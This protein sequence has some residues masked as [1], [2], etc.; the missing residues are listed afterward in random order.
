[1]RNY[2]LGI[3]IGTSAC[4][5]ALF[6]VE[7]TL[8]LSNSEKYPT[9]YPEAGWAEQ[10]PLDWWNAVKKTVQLTIEQSKISPG[11]IAGIGID[12]QSWAAVFLGKNGDILANAPIWLDTRANSICNRLNHQLDPDTIFSVSG[13]PLQPTYT[14]AKVIWLKEHYP[15]LF[16]HTEKVLQAS[17]YILY[18][19]TDQITQDLSHSYGWHCFHME[20]GQWD[21]D[22]AKELGIPRHLLPPLF[23]CHQIVG[24]I[25]HYAASQTGLLAGTPVVAG[26]VDAACATLGAGV[27]HN[28]ECQEQGGQAGGISICI[29]QYKADPRLILSHHVVPGHW[30]LQGGTTGGGG[31]MRWL[32]K[33]LAGEERILADKTGK[34]P[35]TQLNEL[36][37]QISP[38]SDGV[39]FLPYMSGERTPIWDP[40][41]KGVYYGLDFSKTRGH[42]IRSAMEGVAYSLRHNIDVAEEAGCRI[43]NLRATGGSAN[44]L[45]W[46]QIKADITGKDFLVPDSDTATVRGTAILA[47]VGTGI[48][49]DFDEAVNTIIRIK[50]THCSNPKTWDI[51][52][53]NYKIYR[54][55]YED[56]KG[57]MQKTGHA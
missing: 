16:S 50:R 12:S 56:L 42:L 46:T 6:D 51:Y 33:E 53:K 47:G 35:L 23:P 30:L 38:G 2:L 25:S 5:V 17:S 22:M 10:N 15:D 34:T 29:D 13:N 57:L 44:S 45:L 54:E 8:I 55:L 18:K 21:Y 49:S 20:T 11:E 1:M 39:V 48:Y 43:S 4:K 31:V 52:A 3:D 26:G 14:T 40:N 41:A 7:G 19:L 32:E 27:I 28:G 36:A 37:E 9:F 24:Y